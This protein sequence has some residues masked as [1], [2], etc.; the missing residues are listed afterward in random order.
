MNLP[1]IQSNEYFNY[2]KKNMDG[3]PKRE[4]KDNDGGKPLILESKNGSKAA[5][6]LYDSSSRNDKPP[7]HTYAGKSGR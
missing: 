2:N 3:T 7:M 5:S 4:Y 1:T 6:R